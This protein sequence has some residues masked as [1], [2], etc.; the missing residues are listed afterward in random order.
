MPDFKQK[1]GLFSWPFGKT[2]DRSPL[3]SREYARI[4]ARNE[5]DRELRE[6]HPYISDKELDFRWRNGEGEEIYASLIKELPVR[7]TLIEVSEPVKIIIK[8]LF[9]VSAVGV[10]A[11]IITPLAEKGY[12]RWDHI[13]E[14]KRK[15][16]ELKQRKAKMADIA[17]S[18]ST[19]GML[20]AS[21]I[22]QCTRIGVKDVRQCAKLDV[23]QEA[24][25]IQE[26]S[27]VVSAQLAVEQ[28][29]KYFESCNKQFQDEFCLGLVNKAA[30]LSLREPR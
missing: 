15:Q 18:A 8:I 12:E 23:S 11:A 19:V 20:W 30:T 16:E 24:V 10:L 9:M 28:A 17:F 6:K 22:M 4:R 21:A 13:Q 7:K 2:S 3:E 1:G 5:F 14:E 29:D 26:H 25:L 27:A